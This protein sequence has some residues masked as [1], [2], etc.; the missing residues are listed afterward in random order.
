MNKR[1]QN[2]I[3]Q[4]IKAKDNSKPHIMAKVFAEQAVLKMDVQTDNISFPAEVQGVDKITRTLVQDFNNSYDNIYTL[5][6]TNSVNQHQHQNHLSCRWL[7]CM[8]EKSSG[9]L[10]L[11]YGDYHWRFEGQSSGLISQLKI[12]IDDMQ[13]LPEGI[14]TE[15]LCWFDTLPYPWALSSELKTTMPDIEL[16]Y[17]TLQPLF[18]KECL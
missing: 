2:L 8:T 7:V 17:K 15:I 11:G 13:I 12:T 16:L 3:S 18:Q 1:Y 6:I 5:C 4:Y 9:S 14:E 10:R